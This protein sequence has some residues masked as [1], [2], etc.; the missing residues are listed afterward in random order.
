MKKVRN[1]HETT[2]GKSIPGRGGSRCKGPGTGVS[3]AC[4]KNNRSVS[5]EAADSARDGHVSYDGWVKG[6]CKGPSFYLE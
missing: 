4:L 3:Q 2:V 1:E 6:C 5:G